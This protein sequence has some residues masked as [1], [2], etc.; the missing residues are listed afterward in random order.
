MSLP[1]IM[2]AAGIIWRDGRFLAAKRPS[3]AS[4]A[5]YWEFPGGKREAGE[6]IEQALARELEEELGIH[7]VRSIPWR[8]LQHAYPELLVDLHFMHVVEFH[9][10]PVARD[11]Q[12]LCWVTPE[13]AQTL[14]FLPADTDVLL[15]IK[16]PMDSE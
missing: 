16:P 14:E 3:G 10:D 13:E 11:G 15:E 7:S 4:W 1:R 12:E 5:G 8:R 6:S 9:G 2:V